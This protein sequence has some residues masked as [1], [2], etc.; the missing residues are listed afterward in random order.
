MNR[1]E[2]DIPLESAENGETEG[3][4]SDMP[5]Q[6]EAEEAIRTLLRWTG[7]NP[8]RE[9]LLETPKRFVLAMK[10]YTRGYSEDAR[11]ILD[12]VFSESNGYN[13]MVL[14]CDIPF[15]SHCEHHLAPFFGHAHIAYYPSRG[16][17]GLSKLARIVEMYAKR[18]Q[19][20]ENMTSQIAKTL[21]EVIEAH[22]V[23]VMIQAEHLCMAMRGIAKPGTLTLTSHFTGDFVQDM[24]QQTRFL[25]L[26]N[27]HRR[28]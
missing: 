6:E 7:E 24:E 21:D 9:G 12:K 25:T 16:L 26:V 15:Y 8:D 14:V 23:A 5:T 28:Q 17:L 27:Q 1:T 20:Q 13:E 2:Q 19:T 3:I 4:S 10:E 22:G 18:F 11:Q